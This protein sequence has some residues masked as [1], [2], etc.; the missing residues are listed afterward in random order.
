MQGCVG[1]SPA[2]NPKNPEAINFMANEYTECVCR[3]MCGTLQ[4]LQSNNQEPLF[5][6]DLFSFFKAGFLDFGLFYTHTLFCREF[7]YRLSS[8]FLARSSS[9]LQLTAPLFAFFLVF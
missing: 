3:P 4:I 2:F 8:R 9:L 6:L 5:I 7:F 1:R